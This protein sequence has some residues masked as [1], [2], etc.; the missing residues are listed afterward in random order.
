MAIKYSGR[1]AMASTATGFGEVHAQE[2][3]GGMAGWMALGK[4]VARGQGGSTS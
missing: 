3:V 1:P 4:A 2:Q